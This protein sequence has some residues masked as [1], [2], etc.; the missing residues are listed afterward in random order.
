MP[1]DQPLGHEADSHARAQRKTRQSG[2]GPAEYQS[3]VRQR[4]SSEQGDAGEHQMR[5]EQQSDAAEERH[6]RDEAASLAP[7][8]ARGQAHEYQSRCRIDSRGEARRGWGTVDLTVIGPS[9]KLLR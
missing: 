5:I 8:G 2:A 3:I 7:C 4:E 6:H 9:G 1:G